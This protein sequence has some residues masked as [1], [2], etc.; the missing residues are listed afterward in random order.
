MACD[1]RGAYRERIAAG[2]DVGAA[3]NRVKRAFSESLRDCTEK[4]TVWIAL[5]ATQLEAG[6]VTDEVR[7]RALRGIAC[8]EDRDTDPASFPFSPRAVA[9]VRKKLG[10]RARG[11]AKKLS[12]RV[13]PGD[14]GEVFAVRFPHSDREAVVIVCGPSGNDRPAHCGR[15]VLLLDL[16][17]KQVTPESVRRA[18]SAWRPYRRVW[19][20]G[21]SG[22][23]IGCYD[24]SG[25]LPVRRTRRLLRGVVLPAAF[26]RR[27]RMLAETYRSAEL[28]YV[29]EYDVDQWNRYEWADRP[30][31]PGK[32]RRTMR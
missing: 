10:G 25:K 19:H 4:W 15:V 30:G 7:D 31:R 23:V 18:L 27:M 22:R 32:R 13:A 8:C 26:E 14:K 1:V 16:A 2:D 17:V 11:R 12:P 24:A 20:D 21:P 5:A 9:V 28:P 29:I 3:V 6:T